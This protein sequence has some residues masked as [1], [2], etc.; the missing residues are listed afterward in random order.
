M[1]LERF[2]KVGPGHFVLLRGVLEAQDW[3]GVA[4]ERTCWKFMRQKSDASGS[5]TKSVGASSEGEPGA[6]CP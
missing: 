6:F 5:L 1:G 3:A 4:H 2:C